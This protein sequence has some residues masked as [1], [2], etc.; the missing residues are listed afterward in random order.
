MLPEEDDVVNVTAGGTR[1]F[2]EYIWI[3]QAKIRWFFGA[4]HGMT[5]YSS[6]N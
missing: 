1:E 3:I 6:T 5:E 4:A 2:T